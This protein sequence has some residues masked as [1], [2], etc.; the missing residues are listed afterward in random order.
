M[1]SWQQPYLGWTTRS[2]SRQHPTYPRT[3]NTLLPWSSPTLLESPTLSQVLETPIW[4]PY[5]EKKRFGAVWK[6]VLSLEYLLVPPARKI[7]ACR[8]RGGVTW[9]K[10]NSRLL[11]SETVLAG[12][13][14]LLYACGKKHPHATFNVKTF[15]FP[16][17]SVPP[18]IMFICLLLSN[19]SF[20]TPEDQKYS[21]QIVDVCKMVVVYN[22]LSNQTLG[23]Y[24]RLSCGW[25]GI[26]T[27]I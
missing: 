3:W 25:V 20:N 11:Q 17:Y 9:N 27:K 19:V 4:P 18:P 7:S 5:W 23:Y 12:S 10:Y 22:F 21:V 2:P 26:L 15:L 1:Q 24:V 16:C 8:V 6:I 13:I 14:Q